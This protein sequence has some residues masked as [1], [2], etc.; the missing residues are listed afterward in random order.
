MRSS[1][2]C[3]EPSPWQR[4]VSLRWAVAGFRER[5]FPLGI[6]V[7]LTWGLIGFHGVSATATRP[8]VGLV[9]VGI[10]SLIQ[11]HQEMPC[12]AAASTLVKPVPRGS[13]AAHTCRHG[14][15]VLIGRKHRRSSRPV[16]PLDQMSCETG[17]L[18]LDVVRIA[19]AAE[20]RAV[21]PRANRSPQT[22]IRRTIPE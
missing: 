8:T 13:R 7:A 22:P 14:A 3:P 16:R 18:T 12:T 11:I 5:V 15:V 19:G 21:A 4:L 20:G 17:R 2:C 6:H 10:V 9:G 1:E